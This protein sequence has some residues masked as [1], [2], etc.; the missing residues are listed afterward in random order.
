MVASEIGTSWFDTQCGIID[1][2]LDE[3]EAAVRRARDLA[4]IPEAAVTQ[5]AAA[6]ER[7]GL[8]RRRLAE[9][10][11]GGSL[12]DRASAR[13]AVERLESRESEL[14]KRRERIRSIARILDGG[15]S[16]H[17]LPRERQRQESGRDRATSE[18]RVLAESGEPPGLPHPELAPVP[19]IEAAWAADE[20]DHQD[21]ERSSPALGDFLATV[22]RGEWNLCSGD[23]DRAPAPDEAPGQAAGTDEGPAGSGVRATQTAHEGGPTLVSAADPAATVAGTGQTSTG[24]LAKGP[25]DGDAG[26]VRLGVDGPAGPVISMADQREHM[27]GVDH[28]RSPSPPA[29]IGDLT[30]GPAPSRSKASAADDP[31]APRA[32]SFAA[33]RPGDASEALHETAAQDEGEPEAGDVASPGPDLKAEAR[34]PEATSS[35]SLPDP[36]PRFVRGAQPGPWDGPLPEDLL[37]FDSFARTRWLAPDGHIEAAPW[38]AAGFGARVEAGA[39][40]ALSSGSLFELHVFVRALAALG[41]VAPVFADDVEIVARILAASGPATAGVSEARRSEID[42]GIGAGTVLSS[43]AWRTKLLLETIWPASSQALPPDPSI[44]ESAGLDGGW[45]LLCRRA[46]D[47]A[48]RGAELLGL[49]SRRRPGPAADPAQ[50]LAGAR[51]NLQETLKRLGQHAGGKVLRT[52]CKNAWRRFID[53]ARPVLAPLLPVDRGGSDSFDPARLEPVVAGLLARHEEIAD[54]AAARYQDRNH[55]DRAAEEIVAA[56]LRVVGARR[57]VLDASARRRPEAFKDIETSFIDGLLAETDEGL[58]LVRL[59]LRRRLGGPAVEADPLEATWETLCERP[60]LLPFLTATGP[61]PPRL[62]DPATGSRSSGR[63][64][65][66]AVGPGRSGDPSV[67]AAAV[68]LH[69]HRMAG[70]EGPWDLRGKLVEVG[71][72]DL[73]LYLAPGSSAD[74]ASLPI[75]K[76]GLEVDPRV[77]G[78]GALAVLLDHF[79]HPA[80]AGIRAVALGA[81]AVQRGRQDGEAGL[82]RTAERDTFV[83]AW[84]DAVCEW[85]TVALAAEAARRP[86]LPADTLRDIQRHRFIDAAR[87]LVQAAGREGS[88]AFRET[89]WRR[90][91][92]ER[93][94]D[95]LAW[96]AE[97]GQAGAGPGEGIAS[98][99]MRLLSRQ[100]A[101]A[102][103]RDLGS[104]LLTGISRRTQGEVAVLVADGEDP[105]RLRIDRVGLGKLLD[106]L[107][108]TFV[109][110]LARFASITV[111]APRV[112]PSGPA[113]TNDTASL[114]ASRDGT[115]PSLCVVLAPRLTDSVRERV[116]AEFER[117]G[118]AAAL[119]DDLDLCRLLDAVDRSKNA[120][121]ALLE[122]ALEQLPMSKAH[123]FE[124]RE[125]SRSQPEMFVGRRDE[126]EALAERVG[127]SRLFSGRRLG[128]SALLRA[129]ERRY[130]GRALADGTRL[131]AIYV[132]FVGVSSEGQAVNAIIRQV[133]E[134][135]AVGLDSGEESPAERLTAFVGRL[136][137]ERTDESFLLVLDEADLFVEE[138]VIRY[139]QDHERSLTFVM[140][141][142]LEMP[143][144]DRGRQRIR[145]VVSGYRVTNTR[146]GAWGNWGEVLNLDPLPDRD[147]QDLVVKPLARIGIDATL[148]AASIAHRCGNQPA[149]LLKYGQSILRTIELGGRCREGVTV[150]AESVSAAFHDEEVR[151]EIRNLVSMNFQGGHPLPRAVF[152]ALVSELARRPPG[153]VIED[154]ARHIADLLASRGGG[155]LWESEDTSAEVRV[156]EALRQL[157]ERGLLLRPPGLQP[158][159]QDWA[160]RFPHHLVVLIGADPRQQ[161]QEAIAEAARRPSAVD[162]NQ[163]GRAIFPEADLDFARDLLH[164]ED[165]ADHVL[166]LA[167]GWLDGLLDRRCGLSERAG[168]SL[169]QVVD[170]PGAGSNGYIAGG[171]PLLLLGATPLDAD[172]VLQSAGASQPAPLLVGGPDLLRWALAE[173]G[174]HRR[175]VEVIRQGRIAD[176]AFRFWLE[177]VRGIEFHRQADVDRLLA[178]TG[179]IPFLVGVVDRAL[180]DMR[181]ENAPP[182]RVQAAADQ[183]RAALPGIARAH[184]LV[185]REVEILKAIACASDHV[186]PGSAE[187]KAEELRVFLTEM[188]EDL[189]LTGS[190]L[191]TAPTDRQAVE[192][193]CALGLV[194]SLAGRSIATM[195]PL[196]ADDPVRAALAD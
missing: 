127:Y 1:A 87:N 155:A 166:V 109:P 128:K 39:L 188:W 145:F 61:A 111:W 139:Q 81:S 185:P 24:S 121:L 160:L 137:A 156:R 191:G 89:L 8:V 28:V 12:A 189:G 118:H 73:A 144:G 77:E 32:A 135:L 47:A 90:Q 147:A 157:G 120:P 19:W 29:E 117:R 91:A 192:F 170:A 140:R 6:R 18:L 133:Q 163:S 86:E 178:A 42:A 52:H 184:D 33:E 171:G 14:E 63:S 55:M 76:L 64:L 88:P 143:S 161:V 114:V 193:L 124:I 10:G 162:A 20:Q 149:I 44:A 190:A 110:Q 72:P 173:P 134:V 153:S 26:G 158:D 62:A 69:D 187:Q 176:Q 129:V 21:I 58:S 71:R 177:R 68:L 152:W 181:G 51:V 56:S 80:S 36:G 123:P 183:V 25:G 54:R 146:A 50:N 186:K 84:L 49:W 164:D 165:G 78:L 150:S 38:E 9:A 82:P 3:V 5:F 100:Q 98:R 66:P 45:L 122:L 180:A 103:L 27:D 22:S 60:A 107:N 159:V 179:G 195:L 59:A 13:A 17:R 41:Q 96:L 172:R 83:R 105:V 37:S 130:D 136:L 34:G 102:A 97:R 132:P 175:E 48:S 4:E 142:R 104:V 99:W 70:V 168:Y 169:A 46:H 151:S 141:S 138:Q 101:Q 74:T 67:E 106:D 182:E 40:Q 94:T 92:R 85:A 112:T 125:G 30:E 108:P 167:S 15:R 196:G 53:E 57:S 75:L 113:F 79:A 116:L 31:A 23:A 126:A 35:S 154:A 119:L 174:R 194:P 11:E 95:P 7:L 43:A 16:I 2:A 131:R 148:H 65:L 115:G 93:W